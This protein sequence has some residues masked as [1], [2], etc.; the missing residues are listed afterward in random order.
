[1]TPFTQAQLM[2]YISFAKLEK[3]DPVLTDAACKRLVAG[4]V[5][6]R[7]GNNPTG[8]SGGGPA[9]RKTIAA[10][11]RQLESLVRLSE[12]HARMRLSKRVDVLD[13]EEAIRLMDVS[14]QK[15]AVDPRTGT[16]DMNMISTGKGSGAADATAILV[17]ALRELLGGRAPRER[18]S[19]GEVVKVLHGANPEM[20]EPTRN[21][22]VAALRELSEEDEPILV[23]GSAREGG[24]QIT[25]NGLRVS[26]GD[27]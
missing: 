12:A 10:T 9:G 1:M 8:V 24:I 7:R 17:E 16:I 21:D 14:T 11:T 18:L 20:P 2:E 4:Y 15:A 6:M 22:L 25:G 5:V 19:L 27:F 23:Y 3:N 13:V 26:A